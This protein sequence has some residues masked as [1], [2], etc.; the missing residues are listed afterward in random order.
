MV[1]RW[2]TYIS[3]VCFGVLALMV[4]EMTRR[5][6]C[7]ES[8]VVEKM[9]RLTSQGSEA[10]YRC[11]LNKETPFSSYFNSQSK[12]LSTRIQRAERLLESIEPFYR[13]VHVTIFQDR[14]YMFKVQGHQIYIGESLLDAPGHLE[15]AIAKVW[16]RERRDAFFVNE[17]LMEEIFTDFTVFLQEGDLDIGDP[18]THIKTALHR[19]KWPYVIKSVQAYCESPWKM[20]EHYALC[21]NLEEARDELSTKVVELSLRPLILSSWVAAYK[22]L[23][24]KEKMAFVGN[25][26]RL[27]KTE[28]NPELPIVPVTSLVGVGGSP[29]VSA[30]EAV[31]NINLFVSTSQM[32]KNS[33]A[34]RLFVVGISK[35][36]RKVGFQDAFA[37]ASFDVLYVSSEVLTESSPIVQHFMKLAK[38]KPDVHIALRDRQNIW[39]L[40]AKYPIPAKSFG[41]MRAT[42]TVVEK[43]GGFDFNYVMGY[44]N[45][46]E[47]LLIV[48]NCKGK[49]E[50]QFGRFLK[51]GA[52]GFGAQ[53]KGVAFIQFHLPSLMMKRAELTHVSNVFDL[54]RRREVENTIFQS[55]GWKELKWSE[56]AAAYHPKAYVDAIEWF[57]TP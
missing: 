54:I 34:H 19:A 30:A 12:D 28:H 33:E 20:S 9:D 17:E 35:E 5:P 51:D 42:R 15:K 50:L 27:L 25:M 10:V 8:K 21:R 3:F 56:Q 53:N 57:R 49:K 6:L 16:Y 11:A 48:E 29:L 41:Q 44:S 4:V 43:C 24:L 2:L 52:E 13:K 22:D 45:F 23:S 26:A 46:T 31:K 1:S 37:E 14:P 47:K 32:Q 39:M 36:L 18:G 40:P 38:N 55:L 7:I